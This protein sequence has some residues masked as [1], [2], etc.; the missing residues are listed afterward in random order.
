MQRRLSVQSFC[1]SKSRFCR[2]YKQREAIKAPS[3]PEVDEASVL[4]AVQEDRVP[5]NVG[6][7]GPG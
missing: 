4:A 2:L 1:K 7:E 5:K 6:V 3:E